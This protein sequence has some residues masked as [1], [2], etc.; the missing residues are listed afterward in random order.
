MLGEP[1]LARVSASSRTQVLSVS[2]LNRSVRDLLEHRYPLL[3][4]AGEISNLTA[5]RSGHLYFSLK[6]ELAQ[7]RCV[8]FRSRNQ[9]LDWTPC[10]GMKVEVQALLTLYE[11]RGEFQ[12][13]VEAMRRAG[14]G[15]L[16]EAFV[17]LRDKLE[18]EGLFD[19]AAKREPPRFPRAVGVVTSLHAAALHD[20]LTT[21]ARRNPALPVIVYPVPVQGEGAAERIA[22]ALRVAGSRRDCDVLILCRGGGSIEDLRAFNEESVAHAVRACPIP[23]VTGIG[24]EIDFT[25][26]D[27]AADRRAATPTAAAELVSPARRE[28]V[29]SIASL[30]ERLRACLARRLEDRMQHLDYLARRLVHPEAALRA[31]SQLLAHLVARLG[32]A[33]ARALQDRRWRLAQLAQRVRARLPDVG[34]LDARSAEL[35]LRLQRAAHA[36]VERAAT[37]CARIAASLSHLDPAAVLARGY[38]V[39]RDAS[40]RILLSSAALASGDLLDIRFARG[41]ATARVEGARSQSGEEK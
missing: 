3:W 13:N 26:A 10:D 27:F 33:S 4:V 25:I 32:Q 38:S 22:A 20:V 16:F 30:A 28:L 24:H 6:D 2:A 12:L 40:G 36:A 23:V 35:A 15:A 34:R 1:E 19:A 14:L 31:R 21:L 7:V 11:A 18:K 37:R 41:G 17:K 29:A 9:A 39:V 5:A 8:M